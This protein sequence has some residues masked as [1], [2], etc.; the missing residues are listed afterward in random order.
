MQ[1]AVIYA[2][3]SSEK[4]TE[5]S[6]EGQIRT[7]EEY[8][9]RN[10][11]LIIDTYID[12]AMS[13]TNDNRTSFQKM[14]KDSFAKS[15]DMVLVYKL[16]RFSRN[17]YE[18]AIHRR[19][20]KDNG[21]ILKS[22]TENI[23]DSPE[24]IILESL[25][26]GMAEYYS[27]ELAQKVSRG[28]RESWIKGNATGGG[29]CFG[30]DVK[31]K[32]YVINPT[33]AKAVNEIFSKYASGYTAKQIAEFLN[34]NGYT[35]TNGELFDH[36][37][38]L[39]L[40]KKIY[41][42]GYCKRQGVEYTNIYPPIISKELFDKVDALRQQKKHTRTRQLEIYD[43]FLSDKLVCG[44]CN[45]RMFGESGTS[46]SR[47]TIHKYYTCSNRRHGDKT[48]NA[49]SIHKDFLEELVMNTTMKLLNE[50]KQLDYISSQLEKFMNKRQLENE[51]LILLTKQKKQVE[52]AIDN[53]MKAIEDGLCSDLTK[54]RLEKN[55]TLLKQLN[56]EIKKETQLVTRT[57]TKEEIK[58]FLLAINKK[59]KSPPEFK[60]VISRIFI[61]KIIVYPN[62]ID[63]IFNSSDPADSTHENISISEINQEIQGVSKKQSSSTALSL[64]NNCSCQTVSGLL[65]PNCTNQNAFVLFFTKN[66]FGIKV[67]YKR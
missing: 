39:L 15:W 33:E 16:D 21:I 8:A 11:I 4:Q 67:F 64:T 62:K 38:I 29:H 42:T 31:D 54:K 22:A 63:I 13:G 45:N 6:I 57:I 14:L 2:R 51:K 55:E 36:K 7:C 56:C 44:L 28:M 20:L 18:M 25:L 24:G 19:T 12:R 65:L 1:T 26:E 53:I 34:S 50:P 61:N 41:Y 17:K 27:A 35:K 66:F 10:D 49:K 43:Y 58:K 9:E 5:Q 60:K 48:C 32:K 46:G 37:Y 47:G 52:K 23:P 3:Y 30:Y 40:L 59:R